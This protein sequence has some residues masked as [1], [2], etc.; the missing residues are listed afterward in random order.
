MCCRVFDRLGLSVF[1]TY[2]GQVQRQRVVKVCAYARMA[3][4]VPVADAQL[5]PLAI[6]VLVLLYL[7]LPRG[8]VCPFKDRH[9]AR[10]ARLASASGLASRSC[11][12]LASSFAPHVEP[13][14]HQGKPQVIRLQRRLCIFGQISSNESRPRS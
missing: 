12:R 9:A 5:E 14:G 13:D 6:L 2:H 7:S 11:C 10:R 3:G 1:R 8:R 4:V